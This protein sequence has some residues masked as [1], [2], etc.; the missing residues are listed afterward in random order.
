MP[1]D[2]RP[3]VATR[4][5][6]ETIDRAY[7]RAA[8]RAADELRGSV[9][10]HELLLMSNNGFLLAHDELSEVIRRLGQRQKDLEELVSVAKSLEVLARKVKHLEQRLIPAAEENADVR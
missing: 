2:E 3:E 6:A 10:T 4:G 9:D 5:P 1:E 8:K 7:R